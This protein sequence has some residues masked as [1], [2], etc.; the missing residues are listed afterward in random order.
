MDYFKL[1]KKQD[2]EKTALIEDGVSYSYGK[3]VRLVLEKADAMGKQ[4]SVYLIR[5]QRILQQLLSFFACNALGIV[6]VIVPNGQREIPTIKNVPAQACNGVMTSGSAGVP[7]ILFRSYASWADYFPVQN[8]I[9]G[10]DRE[11]VLFAHGSLAFTGNLN[12]YLAQI[13]AGGTIVA[14]NDFQPKR[15]PQIIREHQVNSIYLIPSKL[16]LLPK[17]VREPDL[18]VHTILSGSQSMGRQDAVRLKGCFPEA[19]VILYYGASEL[20]YITYVTDADM[21]DKRNLVGKPFPG[22]SITVKDRAIYVDTRYHVEG[23]TCPYTLS[24]MGYLDQDGNLYF[25]GRSDDIVNRKGRKVST[26]RIANCLEELPQIREAAVVLS[27]RERQFL[28]AVVEWEKAADGREASEI[29]EIR[30]EALFAALRGKLAKFEM[31]NRIYAVRQL[32]HND[33]GKI[34]KKRICQLLQKADS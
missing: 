23:I 12:L 9:F 34:D 22:V 31:P 17:L 15:W 32:P 16:L 30:D 14:Q 19:K 28:T 7:K 21:T 18:R 2:S 5:E 25:E 11:S 20:N 27:D 10:I 3:L 6:P 33:S 4:T 26:L 13:Y 24:D 1:L 29:C 8:R